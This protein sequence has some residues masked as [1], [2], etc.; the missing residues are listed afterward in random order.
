MLDLMNHTWRVELSRKYHSRPSLSN[1]PRRHASGVA[2][3]WIP[4]SE[5]NAA[6]GRYTT[7]ITVNATSVT[8]VASDSVFTTNVRSTPSGSRMNSGMTNGGGRTNMVITAA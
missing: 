4:A 2:C 7:V 5:G 3:R 6:Y 8:N 1:P